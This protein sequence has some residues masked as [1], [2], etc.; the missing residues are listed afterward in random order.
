[1]SITEVVKVAL[2]QQG[3]P[4]VWGKA[5]PDSFDCSGLVVYAFKKGA[6]IDLPHFTGALW[7]K[8]SRVPS[9]EQLML[10]DLVFPSPSHV[11]IY[12]GNNQYVNAPRTGFNVRVNTIPSFWG[13]RRINVPGGGVGGAIDN[14]PDIPGIPDPSDLG[15]L[16]DKVEEISGAVKA[17]YGFLQDINQALRWISDAGNIRRV[18]LFGIGISMVLFGIARAGWGV[19]ATGAAKSTVNTVKKVANG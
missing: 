11:G 7:N 19:T 5:G 1:M 3:K 13:A 6:N 15:D 18:V 10:G 2:A 4:Y 14:L 12:V 9:K 8:G 16:Q 17:I